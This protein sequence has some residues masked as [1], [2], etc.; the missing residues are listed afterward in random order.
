MDVKRNIYHNAQVEKPLSDRNKPEHVYELLLTMMYATP[1]ISLM[2]TFR[3]ELNRK[4]TWWGLT[5]KWFS[6]A[7]HPSPHGITQTTP[8]PPRENKDAEPWMLNDK[9]RW[10]ILPRNMKAIMPFKTTDA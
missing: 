4:P 9:N 2:A 5:R 7:G 8:I 6:V 10:Y 1:S 3:Y